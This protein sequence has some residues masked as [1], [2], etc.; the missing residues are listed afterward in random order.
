MYVQTTNKHTHDSDKSPLDFVKEI[1][2][3][4]FVL[5]C[6]LFTIKP[7]NQIDLGH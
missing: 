1:N 6:V 5:N 7:I 2:T 3:S 4:I